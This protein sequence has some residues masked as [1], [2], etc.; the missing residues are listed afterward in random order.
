MSLKP[1]LRKL[2]GC[3]CYGNVINDQKSF[4]DILIEMLLKINCI[5]QGWQSMVGEFAG[6]CGDIHAQS[7]NCIKENKGSVMV[8]VN[9]LK[10]Y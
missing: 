5:K 9:A 10:K 4:P 1:C 6:V 2:L 3:N 7:K 8:T